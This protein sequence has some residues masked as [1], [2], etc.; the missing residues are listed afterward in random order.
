[1][2][3]VVPMTARECH[4]VRQRIETVMTLTAGRALELVGLASTLMIGGGTAID[5]S[6]TAHVR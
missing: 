3:L 5:A 6:G 1:M 4:L 2:T